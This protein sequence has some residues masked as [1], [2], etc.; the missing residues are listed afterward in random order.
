MANLMDDLKIALADVNAKK[1]VLETASIAVQKASA[2]YEVSVYTV[3]NLRLSLN[4]LVNKEL[5]AAGISPV[6]SRV[7]QSE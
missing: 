1:K 2:D 7:N 6:D 4:E 3:Q 5:A